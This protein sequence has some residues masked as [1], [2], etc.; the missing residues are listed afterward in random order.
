MNEQKLSEIINAS[1]FGLA[2]HEIIV[3]EQGTPIDY[4]FLEVNPAFEQLT[5]LS[6]KDII[7]K[8]VKEAI[9]GIEKADFDWITFF[10]KVALEGGNETFEQYST[11][12]N[13]WY[14]GTAYSSKK[15]F[16]TASFV[17]ITEQKKQTDELESFFTVN[18]DLLCIA[19]MEGNFV[20]TNEAWVRILGYTNEDLNTKK[21][22]EFIH[23]DDMQA[24]FDAMS[25]LG[26]GEEVLNFTNRY[27][28]KDGAYKYIEWRS[29]PKGN[30]IYAAARDITVRKKAE[31]ELKERERQISQI[32]INTPAVI[33]NYSVDQGG[34][35]DLQ[36]ISAKVEEI[37]GF[38]PMDFIGHMDYFAS[39]VHPDDIE[40][41]FVAISSLKTRDS[42][43]IEYRF[44]DVKGNWRWLMDKHSVNV[45]S[46]NGFEV[47]GVW[48]DITDRKEVEDELRKSEAIKL[49]MVSNIGDVIVIIDKD[50]IN[51]YKS[52]S[53]EKWFGWKPEDLIGKSTWNN[54][55]PEDLEAS[56]K[57]IQSLTCEPNA[58]GTT[59]LRYL[60]KDGNYCSIELTVT[61]LLQDTDIQ[62]FLGNYHDI[63]ERKQTEK[64]IDE[65]NNRLKLAQEVGNVG[66]WEHDFITNIVTWSEHTYKIYEAEP[67][68]FEVNFENIVSHHPKGEKE[69]VLA[70]F[71]KAIAE[72]ND[73]YVEHGIITCKG[74]SRVV[75][76]SGRLIL[77]EDGEPLKLVG[78]VADI[79]ERKK[80][81]E[82]LLE[83]ELRFSAAIEGT[84]AGIW[85]WDMVKNEVVFSVQWKAMLGYEDAE[86]ENS[87]E[88]WKNL[89]H[90]DDVVAIEKSLSDHLSGLTEK[91]EII[92]RCRHKDGSWH[93]I[94]TRGKILRDTGGI[95]YR[96][97]GT[98]IDISVEKQAQ[99]ELKRQTR[100]QEFLMELSGTYISLPV[101][102][103]EEAIKQ[104]LGK[105]GQ[106]IGVDRVYIFKYDDE[107]ETSSNTHEWC[108]DGVLPQID[109]LQDVPN[110]MIPDWIETTRRGDIMLIPDVLAL[111]EQSGVRQV[112]EPQGVLSL[113]AIPMMDE[114]KCIGFAG[115]D[116]VKNYH[117]YGID[118]QKLLT[119]FIG[120]LVN[121]T[122]RRTMENALNEAIIRAEVAN[123]AKS[124]FLANMSHEIR[125][126]LNAVL[127]MGQLLA[128][129]QL[130]SHQRD[131][132]KKID[133]S[134]KLLLGVVND[135]LDISK[136][137]A[138]KLEL[139]HQPFKLHDMLNDI[140]TMFASSAQKKGLEL[141]LNADV[142][143][144]RAFVGDS[145]RLGQV[146][147]NLFS[148]ALKF[149]E[150]GHVSMHIRKAIKEPSS[151]DACLLTFSV[152][153]SGIGMDE[154]QMGRL[155]HAF[156][157]ADSS[158]TRK[159]G[160]TGLGLV[161]S[162][163]LV[164]AMGGTLEVTS[165]HG[166]GSSFYFTIELLKASHHTGITE[167]PA[168]LSDD[169]NFLVVDDQEIARNVLRVILE[170]WNVG[171]V[172]A[173]SGMEAIEAVLA[174]QEQNTAFDFI[175]MDWKMPGE[176]DGLAAIRHLNY[177]HE[178]GTLTGK[179]TPIFVISAY[180]RDEIPRSESRLY[181]AF[182]GKPVIA[183][184]LFDAMMQATGGK[185]GTVHETCSA[186]I[187]CFSGYTIL[188]VE[189]N[190]LNQEVA[191]GFVSKTEAKVIVAE[192]GEVAL[193]CL[194]ENRIDLV[195]MD[196]Q[197]PVMSGF[198]ATAEIRRRELESSVST[199]LPIIA[200]SA[201]VMEDDRIQAAK[202]GVDGHLGKPI[203][204]QE[205]YA[206]MGQYLKRTGTI[207]AEINSAEETAE[208]FP[209]LDGFD[210]EQGKASAQGK[211]AIYKKLLRSLYTQ[212]TGAFAGFPDRMSSLTFEE[213][214]HEAHTIKGTA[215]T[216]GAI[217]LA[218]AA[219]AIDKI[220]TERKVP[221][222][223]MIH[224]LRESLASA[225]E[226][227]APQL[228]IER[229]AVT[230]DEEEGYHAT[231]ILLKILRNNELADDA[232]I[233]TVMAFVEAKSGSE[234]AGVLRRSIEEFDMDAAAS[235]IGKFQKGAW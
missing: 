172:E 50:G 67:D 70:A 136:I 188:L 212:L 14:Q 36:F 153:D 222:E 132:L 234:E 225:K 163:R 114:G 122:K 200:L 62:G 42:M 184:E 56:Q 117:S 55:H 73:L 102:Q 126:P 41:L 29:H 10:G 68:N 144:P 93:W 165:A 152:E 185:I 86:I 40:R 104:S 8:T 82:A 20:K 4:R 37:L 147:T 192:N 173:A 47:S 72:K 32:L 177:L 210:S 43:S 83:S 174:A 171:V 109:E 214:Q 125:T 106:F 94:M 34:N 66:S 221:T 63:T 120:V 167:R 75:V 215:A 31:D 21:F 155:F 111:P 65:N 64:K 76:E 124:E 54:V 23:P 182:L 134:S 154:E 186:L 139:D 38:Q 201:A 91:Y 169:M 143:L 26:K 206:I 227:I 180:N 160:G 166:E 35:P 118:E 28:C 224:E 217:R 97:I 51:K 95:P 13:R 218:S 85:D 7:G 193:K 2:H 59:E 11:P 44:K 90:P 22:L 128:D 110:S 191:T 24:T 202:A 88:G 178:T 116:S 3:D 226:Q 60:K 229:T 33:Y 18:L 99:E 113:I 119:V 189:D 235:F 79:T 220:C 16:F 12:L 148:N 207:S 69:K 81:E 71:N 107:K 100:M 175:L 58:T 146:F 168:V 232:V 30:L 108:N 138:G 46:D 87:F 195:L 5:G 162:S 45:R 27:R 84:E 219:A 133:R 78:S 181:K 161:I 92:H 176:M 230:V 123:K 223:A 1:P 130:N 80:A 228:T 53:I 199:H 129:T 164:E 158:T 74:N 170:S 197:M 96:W 157:Q 131:Y 151:K 137:E 150:T 179:E 135:V 209:V 112:L 208:A 203:D 105:L 52:P 17:D 140:R 25:N 233:E 103:L 149:T 48:S 57:F 183:S 205:L 198:A 159:Y 9:P 15:G 61:N 204:S 141:V 211:R 127:G 194:E 77:S 6:E 115:F 156:S 213:I 49:K 19:D 142:N 216:V 190:E 98:N 89:W 187:P 121:V 196:L 231:D 39:C 101:E 145:M